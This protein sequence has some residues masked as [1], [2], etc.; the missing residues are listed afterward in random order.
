MRRATSSGSGPVSGVVS[1]SSSLR[2]RHFV[3]LDLG[4]GSSSTSSAISSNW[5]ASMSAKPMHDL[6]QALLAFQVLVVFLQQHLDRP[7]EAGQRLLHLHQAF[8]DALGDGD[9]AF[10]REQLHRAHLA[11]V[12][13][14]RVGGAADLAVQRGQRGD[15]FLGGVLVVAGRCRRSGTSKV[16]ASGATSCTSMPMSLIMPMMSSICSGST[17]SSAGGR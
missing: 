2:R 4:L 10:A 3:V 9:F 5:R 14:H 6:G 13:A 11:H 1:S 7:R 15:G 8:L 17:M 16:S 12:H